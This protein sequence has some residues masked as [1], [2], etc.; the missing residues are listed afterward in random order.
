MNVLVKVGRR[1]PRPIRESVRKATQRS[2]RSLPGRRI[3]WGDVARRAP[4]SSVYG[5][6]RG[7]PVDR[8]YINAF[9]TRNRHFITGSVLEVRSALYAQRHGTPTEITVLDINRANPEATLIA[10]LNEPDSLPE[11]AYDCVI[12]TQTLQYT[13]PAVALRNIDRSLRPGGAAL[14]TVPCL[15]RIDPEAA[16]TDLWRWTPQGLRQACEDAGLQ[17]E[18]EGHGNS[19]AAAACMLGAA[20]E[21]IPP[22]G[23]TDEDPAFPVVACAVIQ[24]TG[25]TSPTGATWGSRGSAP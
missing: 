21:E 15:G 14:V 13:R 17:A 7:L 10:D 3:D 8:F 20:V 2:N 22:G 24:R 1:I 16:G 9:M 12:L 25:P 23:L 5:W 6:D 4:F 19:L 11:A 18:V